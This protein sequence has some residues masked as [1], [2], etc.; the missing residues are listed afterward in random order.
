[1]GSLI[2]TM[3]GWNL[4]LRFGLEVACLLGIG[5]AGWLVAPVLGVAGSVAA[6]LA[7]GVLAV[8]DDPSRNG[9]APVPVNGWVRL[10]IELAVFVGGV[11]GW[12]VAG[13]LAVS[14]TVA[15]LLVVHHVVASPRLRW[16]LRQ[17]ASR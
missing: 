12:L 9:H 13:R 4:L 10:L 15:A 8:P 11:V 6:A 1:M 2:P 3:Q 16:L 7:W 14:A 17:R 5:V